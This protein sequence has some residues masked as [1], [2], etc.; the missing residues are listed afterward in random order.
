MDE[1]ANIDAED[2]SDWQVRIGREVVNGERKY[3]IQFSLKT[4]DQPNGED[5]SC[6]LVEREELDNGLNKSHYDGV[7]VQGKHR[8]LYLD[9]IDT[10]TTTVRHFY[11][12]SGSREWKKGNVPVNTKQLKALVKDYV[13]WVRAE[14]FKT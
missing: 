4:T 12:A 7:G 3:R 6:C 5:K 10:D 1:A 13:D 11:I 9:G 8:D 2:G 14:P